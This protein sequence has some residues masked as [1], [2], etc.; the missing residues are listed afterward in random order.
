M[1]REALD[2]QQ[3]D[4]AGVSALA[5]ANSEL[6]GADGVSFT[7]NGRVFLL[8]YNTTAGAIDVTIET[9]AT[10]DSDLEVDDRVITVPANGAMLAGVFPT[11]LYN[12]AGGAVHVDVAIG[13]VDEIRACAFFSR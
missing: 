5:A 6:I 7:N 13:D 1:S 8:L 10:F 9:P 2:I 3:L 4:T 11:H 12:Q